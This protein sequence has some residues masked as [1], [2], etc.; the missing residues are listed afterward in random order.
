MAGAPSTGRALHIDRALSNIVINRRPEG[1]IAD[2]FLPVTNV[3]KQTDFYWKFD[4]YQFRTYKP[5]MTDRSPGG[6]AKKI[7]V[8]VGTDTYAARNYAIGAQWTVEDEVNAD[9][10]LQWA[11]TNAEVAMDT[12]MMDYEVRLADIATNTSNV[13][14]VT[15]INSAWSDADNSSPYDDL[16]TKLENFRQRTGR[17]ANTLIIPEQVMVQLR[18]N[19]Q[20]RSIIFGDN[21]GLV[22]VNQMV[23]LFPGIEQIFV[24]SALVNTQEEQAT[25][26]GSGTL[27]NVWQNHCWLL[28]RRMLTG[29]NV[30]TWLQAFRWT[31]PM[32]GVPFAVR[33]FFDEKTLTHEVELAYYQD[34]KIVSADLCERIADVSSL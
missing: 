7:S 24:P 28:D 10:I 25:I 26:N 12:L 9:E 14:T 19:N 21:G 33:R 23:G 3:S 13:G 34:E 11:R 4:H 29:R 22:N 16:N 5:N 6:R 18:R 20:L 31:S 32:F 27:A 15:T 8:N 17:R 2:D 1:F 30:D